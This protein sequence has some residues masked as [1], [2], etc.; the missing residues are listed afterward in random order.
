MNFIQ[1]KK[2]REELHLENVSL[3]EYIR[4]HN[5]LGAA[6]EALDFSIISRFSNNVLE[7]IFAVDFFS[8]GINLSFGSES[9]EN[10]EVQVEALRRISSRSYV[11]LVLSDQDLCQDDSASLADIQSR[12][13]ALF[14]LAQEI[15]NLNFLVTPVLATGIQ[16]NPEFWGEVNSYIKKMAELAPTVN[17]LDGLNFK[18]KNANSVVDRDSPLIQNQ[19]LTLSGMRALSMSVLTEI[20]RQVIPGAKLILLDADNTLWNG[21]LGELG[22]DGVTK[23]FE[24]PN[25]GFTSLQHQLIRMHSAGI[26]LAILSKNN[27]KDIEEVLNSDSQMPLKFEHFSYLSANWEDKWSNAKKI[28]VEMNLGLNSFVFLDDN[29]VERQLMRELIP[30]IFTPEP[31]S[32]GTFIE[33][34]E[35]LIPLSARKT[36]MEDL[37]R[38]NYYQQANHVHDEAK[39]FSDHISFLVSLDMEAKVTRNNNLDKDRAIQLIQKTN[40]FNMT[41]LRLD[42]FQLESY[43]CSSNFLFF[44]VSLKDKF[45]HNG[46]VLL[47]C[48]ELKDNGHSEIAIYNM[49]CRTIGRNLEFEFLNWAASKL[50]SEYKVMTLS[51]NVNVTTRNEPFVGF[52]SSA[53]FEEIGNN[54]YVIDLTQRN[55]NSPSQTI[56]ISEE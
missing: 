32:D 34:L 8:F 26:L 20:S 25:Y 38:A 14:I 33:L 51:V 55:L 23:Q 4:L 49:S 5:S 53:G 39:R 42:T 52:F 40:Q 50:V 21:I 17:Y 37:H 7:K 36:T 48:F 22:V 47:A 9:F 30:E 10:L 3:L 27:Q 15:T 16:R 28:A 31:S 29:P 24:T 43:L 2:H 11:L 44:Q 45:G 56:K 54:Q 1:A 12:I 18:W 41:G 35:K 13:D 6:S 46:N 19:P